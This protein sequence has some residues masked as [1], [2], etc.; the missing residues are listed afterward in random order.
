MRAPDALPWRCDAATSVLRIARFADPS[1]SHGAGICR[2]Q[3]HGQ[4]DG[5]ITTIFKI[6]TLR[7]TWL[8]RELFA[9]LADQLY[10]TFIEPNHR[11]HR[12][13][14]VRH[15]HRARPPAVRPRC[16]QPAA[17][18][19]ASANSPRVQRLHPS[20][21]AEQAEATSN[22]VCLPDCLRA[23]VGGP[24]RSARVPGCLARCAA[25][26][27]RPS[28]RQPRGCPRSP[29]RCRQQDLCQG[30]LRSTRY[31]MFIDDPPLL[32]ATMYS[33]A[34]SQRGFTSK[35]GQYLAFIH[36]CTLV[37]ARRPLEADM[38]RF[39]RDTPPIVHQMVPGLKTAGLIPTRAMGPA[40][41]RGS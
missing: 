34:D 35:H 14:P 33:A 9:H 16:Y 24:P 15:R 26:S 37:I 2:C 36:A 27:A 20:V 22:A 13:N 8:S 18:T 28:I 10:R 41:C 17:R 23:G 4:I 11:T 19:T 12:I 39:C 21:R 38:I 1:S 7:L 3:K 32:R 30:P 31:R 5:A 29:R 40:R 6:L 25:L